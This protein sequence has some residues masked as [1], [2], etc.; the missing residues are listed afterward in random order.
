MDI[1]NYFQYADDTIYYNHAKKSNHCKEDYYPHS[2]DI[3]EIIFFKRGKIIYTVDGRQYRLS[4]N[5]LV[6]S[7]PLD[8]HCISIG[9]NEDYERYNI[10]IDEKTLPFDIYTRIPINLDVV[11]FDSNQTVINIFDKMDYYCNRLKGLELKLM[12]KNLIQE[13]FINVML[14]AESA[15]ENTYTQTNTLVCSAITYID[16]NLL[17][18]TG[19]EEICRELFIT[20]SHLHHLFIKHLKISPKKYIT[21]KRLALAQ[22]EIC[23]GVKPTE[24]YAKCGFSDYSAFYRA[25][26]AHFGHKPSER[27]SAERTIITHDNTPIKSSV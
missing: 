25:Y 8:I 9:G 23:A 12:L 27:L 22:R 4:R 13:I 19:I 20:K 6:I 2:H 16:K 7:R 24:V 17:T 10:L 15:R 1:E 5:D 18:L 14:E 21:S 11:S 3:V 26:R